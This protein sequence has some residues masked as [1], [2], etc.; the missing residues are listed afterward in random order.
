MSEQTGKKLKILSTVVLSAQTVVFLVFAFLF[1]KTNIVYSFIFVALALVSALLLIPFVK[2]SDSIRK[3]KGKNE[4]E[5]QD[6]LSFTDMYA[7]S[8]IETAILESAKMDKA[9]DEDNMA[10]KQIRVGVKRSSPMSEDFTREVTLPM[11][12]IFSF[13]PVCSDI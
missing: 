3:A 9:E 5:E 12:R 4:E 13:F 1:F 2:M 10:T 6:K 8:Y 7:P 11:D